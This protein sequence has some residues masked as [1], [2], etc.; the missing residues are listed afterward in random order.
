MPR[1]PITAIEQHLPKGRT[2]PTQ[3]EALLAADPPVSVEWNGF[4]HYSLKRSA[5]K[6]AVPFLRLPD[7]GLVAF[8]FREPSTSTPI[9]H[10]GGH[11]ELEVIASDFEQFLKAINMKSTGLGDFDDADPPLRISTVKGRPRRK[12]LASLQTKLNLWFECHTSLR[13]PTNTTASEALRRQVVAV[14]EAMLRDGKSKIYDLDSTWW[15]MSFQIAI[16][17]KG[18]RITYLDYGKWYNVP[19]KYKLVP[20]VNDL[21]LLVKHKNR[22]RYEL[23]VA[24]YGGVSI[25]RD[26]E[27]LIVPPDC[28]D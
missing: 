22:K 20:L 15:S 8:W 11:G 25:D 21:L 9:I 26:Q 28:D 14:A 7:G 12:E 6:E 23:S 19:L 4:K 1:N 24:S 2:L 16:S 18:I 13:K 5:S 10:I 3:F 27:L 17:T